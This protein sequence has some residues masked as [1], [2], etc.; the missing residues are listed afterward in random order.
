MMFD[1]VRAHEALVPNLADLREAASPNCGFVVYRV[2]LSPFALHGR[3][4]DSAFSDGP[5]D[6]CRM[7]LVFVGR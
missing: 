6:P 2:Q 5:A 3:M 7:F 1:H 4:A